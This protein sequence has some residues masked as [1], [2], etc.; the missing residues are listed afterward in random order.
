VSDPANDRIKRFLEK[1][2]QEAEITKQLNQQEKERERE[3]Q[4]N[5]RRIR[6]KWGQDTQI[7]RAVLTDLMQKMAGVGSDLSLQDEGAGRNAIAA[8]LITG[9]FDGKRVHFMLEVRAD[10]TIDPKTGEAPISVLTADRAA[11]EALILDLL[12]VE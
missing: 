7:I 9:R 12:G 11:Y 10:G 5:I 3:Y 2:D 6:A 8:A 4:D 1:R